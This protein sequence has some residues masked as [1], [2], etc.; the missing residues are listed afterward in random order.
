M[1]MRLV[2]VG[3]VS[4]LGFSV[5]GACSGTDRKFGTNGGAD[6]GGANSGGASAGRGAAAGASGNPNPSEAGHAGV[7]DNTDPEGG[8]AGDANGAGAGG[9][10]EEVGG[11]PS[12]N[13]GGAGVGGVPSNGGGGAG[14]GA[15]TCNACANGFA[16]STTTCKTTC[17]ADTDCLADRF[18]SSGQCRLDA[19]QVSIG[20][21]HACILLADKTVSC[22]GKNDRSQLGTASSSASATP[23]QVKF[24]ENV[25][26]IAV[27]DGVTLALRGDGT[28]VFWGTRYTA[29]N[30]SIGQYTTVASQ[31][32][33]L[34]EG[35]SAVKQI[36]AGA[37]SNGCA[38]LAD[39]SVRC[40]GL[41]EMG[42]L[43]NG[44]YDFSVSPVVVSGVSGAT[45]M[46]FGYAFACAQTSS[47]MKCWGNNF[48]GQLG[49]YADSVSN[50]PQTIAGLS[51][52]VS[53]LRTGDSSAC[54]LM[55]NGTI[56]CWGANDSG[57][58]G[59][60][61]SGTTEKIPVTVSAIPGVTDLSLGAVHTC[62]LLT[63]GT[64]RCWGQNYDG[65]VGNGNKTSPITTPATVQG[66]SG[67]IAVA[68]G[69]YTTCTTLTNGSVKCFG[70]IVGADSTDDHYVGAATVW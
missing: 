64:V 56:Q 24:L 18:C 16:C 13:G 55:T 41:N 54:V 8:A 9:T 61:T 66:I 5:V 63:G 40:W 36:A 6:S 29:F 30:A 51:G 1:M 3:L 4:C 27:G 57:Q 65:Q 17:T 25:Q 12:N 47:A 59:N 43:G 14:G 10:L 37:R 68:A 53:K 44:T 52:T 50:T 31:Y 2:S 69:S 58:L 62:A 35:L 7:A 26:F 23:V 33:T 38:A 42:Q 49:S 34:L 39:G 21:S 67:A 70:R 32:P 19:V 46:G 48:G 22:W 28:V 15:P 45:G 11:A 60:G 20:S